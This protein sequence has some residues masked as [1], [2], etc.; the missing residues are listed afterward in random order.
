V[1]NKKKTTLERIQEMTLL[2]RDV[3]GEVESVEVALG[4]GV[5]VPLESWSRLFRTV[6]QLVDVRDAVR[7]DVHESNVT[8]PSSLS[9][10]ERTLT[11]ARLIKVGDS[12]ERGETLPDGVVRSVRSQPDEIT[13]YFQDDSALAVPRDEFLVKV[14][15][16]KR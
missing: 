6:S 14:T 8:S 4:R 7:V 10:V 15:S 3:V 16:G 5:T 2:A 12:V 13:L 1:S 9:T 11:L